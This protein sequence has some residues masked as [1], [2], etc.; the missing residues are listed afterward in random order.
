MAVVS[1]EPARFAR[2]RTEWLELPAFWGALAIVV[3]WLAVLFVGVFGPS[4]TSHNG[5]DNVG[6]GSSVPAV[7]VVAPCAVLATWLIA[8]NAFRRPSG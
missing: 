8:R 6:T 1:H 7:V 3:V 2:S 5:V 4:I